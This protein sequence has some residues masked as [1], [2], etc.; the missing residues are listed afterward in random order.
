MFETT[1]PARSILRSLPRLINLPCR[2]PPAYPAEPG[3]PNLPCRVPPAYPAE[4]GQPTLLDRPHLP[5]RATSPFPVKPPL[6]RRKTY[7][8]RAQK[9]AMPSRRRIIYPA[10]TSCNLRD[11]AGN[12]LR[13]QKTAPNTS[14]PRKTYPAECKGPGASC[15]GG[16]RLPETSPLAP[17]WPTPLSEGSHDPLT[18]CCFS[19]RD[20][21]SRP[22]VTAHRMCECKT[23]Q[24]RKPLSV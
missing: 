2:V 5:C 4:L 17:T 13:C 3:Q 9:R 19:G 1:Y 22:A 20:E 18:E 24:K 7:P 15:A 11:K 12:K 23:G 16:K 6:L 8:A 10:T 14:D 21:P